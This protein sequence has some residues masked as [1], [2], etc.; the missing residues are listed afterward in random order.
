MAWHLTTIFLVTFLICSCHSLST[1]DE[2]DSCYSF[3]GGS[4]YPAEGPK[5]DHMLQT[6]KAVS[7]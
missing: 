3:A 7:K 6:T 2:N 4:V 1:S 5:G